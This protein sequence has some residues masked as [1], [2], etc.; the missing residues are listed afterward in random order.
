LNSSD[1]RVKWALIVGLAL[2]MAYVA[3]SGAAAGPR[4]DPLAVEADAAAI[5]VYATQLPDAAPYPFA[6]LLREPEHGPRVLHT[7]PPAAPPARPA[8]PPAVKP[9]ARSILSPGGCP[10]GVCPARQPARQPQQPQR[11]WRFRR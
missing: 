8:A 2:A 6:N 7:A 4:F 11:G 10:G 9:A 1:P 3:T 5:A